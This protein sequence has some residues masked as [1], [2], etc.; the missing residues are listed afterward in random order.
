MMTI[1]LDR[2]SLLRDHLAT[3]WLRAYAV[4]DL[5]E[6]DRLRARSHAVSRKIAEIADPRPRQESNL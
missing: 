4:D 3:A 1:T 6:M 5:D 2:L